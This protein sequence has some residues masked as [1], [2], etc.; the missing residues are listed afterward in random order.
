MPNSVAHLV[1]LGQQGL[2]IARVALEDRHRHGDALL[3]GQQAVVD[4]ELPFLAVAVVSQ[5]GQGTGHALEVARRQV[6]ERKA[7][8]IQV[9]GCQ[10]LL[11]MGLTFQQ[12]V[13]GLVQFVLIG[14]AHA[15]HLGQRRA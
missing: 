2:G 12:P 8:V 3:V 14:L 6:V 4:L 9:T 11:D 7:A 13:H 5:L 1:D 10:L 15:E